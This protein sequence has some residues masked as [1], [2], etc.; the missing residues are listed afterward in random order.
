MYSYDRR[1]KTAAKMDL[2][3]KWRNIIEKHTEAEMIE[4]Q[5]VLKAA[6]GPL[7]SVG[8]DLDLRL[9]SIGKYY[10]GS[11]GVRLEG[12]LF[13]KERDENTFKIFEEYSGSE[14]AQKVSARLNEALGFHGTPEHKGNGIWEVDIT[15][16]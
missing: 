5:G 16:S 12:Y 6:V 14:A 4:L 11:D 7:R 13:V 10:H 8:L 2:Y 3:D 1:N 15:E 9:S